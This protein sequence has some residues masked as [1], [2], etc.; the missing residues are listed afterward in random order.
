MNNT[1]DPVDSLDGPI[2]GTNELRNGPSPSHE[3]EA[4]V[5]EALRRERLIRQSPV[6]SRTMLLAASIALFATGAATGHLLRGTT[7]AQPVAGSRYLLLLTG[8]AQPA[9]DPAA[10]TAEYAAWANQLSRQG[11]PVSGEELTDQAE[12]VGVAPAERLAALASVAGYFVVTAAN[13]AVAAELAR[14]CPH[15]KYGGAVVVRRIETR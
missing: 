13:D 10:R 3:L 11:T 9:D 2:A 14:D 5:V 1:H 15:V 8:T 7:P 4:R 12:S 6:W